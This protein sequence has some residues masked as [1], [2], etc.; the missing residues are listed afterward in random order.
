MSTSLADERRRR[1]GVLV[2]GASGFI[3]GHI[4]RD[5]RDVG[6]IGASR[7][8]P[9]NATAGS[10]AGAPAGAP[11]DGSIKWAAPWNSA[12]EGSMARSLEGID[13]LVHAAGRAHVLREDATDPLRA[14]REGNVDPTR[15]AVRA[16]VAAGVRRV[17][18]LSSVS[19][20]GEGN[21]DP[22]WTESTPLV[23]S[24]PY[25]ISRKES[26]EVALAE[27]GS[28]LEVIILRLPMVYGPG[29]K[30]N[31]LRLFDLVH[32][33]LPIPLGAVVNT[34]ST[35]YVGNVVFAVRRLLEMA[36]A[37]G[38]ARPVIPTSASMTALVAD[39]GTV[40]TPQFVREIA[41]A[42]GCRARLLSV[43]IPLL[44]LIATLGSAV[45]GQRFPLSRDALAR[46]S[47]SLVVDAT[48]LARIVGAPPVSRVEGLRATAE[49]YL[50]R[51]RQ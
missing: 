16:A 41:Q 30:G 42:L 46:L 45:L 25:G 32:S 9:A 10:P 50:R 51:A 35:L 1:K 26:E 40:S 4:A 47:G 38:A 7:R 44:Q 24:T 27:A 18:L 2:T 49:W 23:P 8:P 20:H 34:R 43:P 39:E 19:V 14:F 48:P 6:A 22:V 15:A 29:M 12:D 5:L 37:P 33:G 11:T 3:G 21:D 36:T 13:T 17:I 28:A 31:P